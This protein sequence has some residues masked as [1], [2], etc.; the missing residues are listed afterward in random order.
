MQRSNS[1]DAAEEEDIVLS[2]SVVMIS[3][4]TVLIKPWNDVFS[5]NP[6]KQNGVTICEQFLSVP[7][8]MW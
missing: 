7:E 1:L 3:D 2:L 6:L 5:L 8:L 4:F